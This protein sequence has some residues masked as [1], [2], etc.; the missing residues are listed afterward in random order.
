MGSKT[1]RSLYSVT[2]FAA[3]V[4]Y[5]ACNGSSAMFTTRAP[6]SVVLIH[7]GVL[8]SPLSF[9]EKTADVI[10]SGLRF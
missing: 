9:L 8:P 7:G 1:M 10:L 3:G 4:R 2:Y 6:H 5:V